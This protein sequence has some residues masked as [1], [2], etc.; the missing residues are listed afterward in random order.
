MCAKFLCKNCPPHSFLS[1]GKFS[2]EWFVSSLKRIYQKN[3]IQRRLNLQ[4]T[5][6]E[7]T[8]SNASI[9]CLPPILIA[10]VLSFTAERK[11]SFEVNIEFYF[12]KCL[13][14][15]YVLLA[16]ALPAC[17]SFTIWKNCVKRAWLFPRSFVTKSKTIG[18]ASGTTHGGQGPTTAGSPSTGPCTATCGPTGPRRPWNSP[19][20]PSRTTMAR[21]SLHSR[22]GRFCLTICR[23]NWVPS[24]L[25]VWHYEGFAVFVVAILIRWSL[26]LTVV[27][28]QTN[29]L[30]VQSN[31]IL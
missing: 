25:N 19:T 24:F 2:T 4:C 13:Q 10:I 21:P 20:T 11:S 9:I 14:R 1:W 22:P 12:R 23:V 26:A 17:A 27:F 3:V 29:D 30:F 18:A 5:V 8:F 7:N 16:P 28:L 15:E 6:F 31:S